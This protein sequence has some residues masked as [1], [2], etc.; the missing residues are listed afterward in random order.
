LVSCKR[1]VD[2]R[3][4]RCCPMEDETM[5]DEALMKLYE[6]VKAGRKPTVREMSSEARRDYNRE[7]KRRSRAADRV[8][9]T[10]TVT[11]AVKRQALADA[12]LAVLATGTEGSAA[13]Q[14]VLDS[15]FSAKPAVALRI[16]AEAKSGRLRPMHLKS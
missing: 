9:G 2:D 13:I 11:D 5:N 3:R 7:A 10:A 16:A 14:K 6:A 1:R 12:A 8:S 4:G 15:I